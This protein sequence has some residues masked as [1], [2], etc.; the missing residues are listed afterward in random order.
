ME[1]ANE[2]FDATMTNVVRWQE[3]PAG[4]K[5]IASDTFLQV[6]LRAREILRG[7]GWFA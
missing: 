6:L 7:K 2:R 4:G 1:K 3:G 5:Q